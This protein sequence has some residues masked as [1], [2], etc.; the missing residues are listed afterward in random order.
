LK[1]LFI[2]DIVGKPGRKTV[3]ELLPGLKRELGCEAVIA[4]GEN[5]SGGLG[6]TPGVFTELLDTGVD[7]VTSGNHIWKRK[8]I[9]PLLDDPRLLRPANYPD[10]A[11]GTGCGVLETSAGVRVGVLNLMGRTFL[12]PGTDCP[13]RTADRLLENLAGTRIIIVDFHA[14]ATSEKLAMGLYLDGRVSAVIGTHTHIQTS[15]CR[16]LPGGTAYITDA[17]MTGSNSGIIGAE[18]EEILKKFLTGIP[19]RFK[20][21]KGEERLEGAVIEVDEST[22]KASEIISVRVGR[23]S[24][25]GEK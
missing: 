23:G 20:V 1:I 3:R 4:N 21:A 8:E 10:P 15:D 6:L 16:V 12:E 25:R 2:G 7:L 18:K 22:G 5:S 19:F 9:Y 17:G 11:P 13:F 14:E 24:G